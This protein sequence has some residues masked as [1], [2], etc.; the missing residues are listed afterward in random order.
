MA[1]W[2]QKST[3][4]NLSLSVPSAHTMRDLTGTGTRLLVEQLCYVIKEIA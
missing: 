1:Q 2:A 4:A 3:T